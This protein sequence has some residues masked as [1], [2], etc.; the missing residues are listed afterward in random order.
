MCVPDTGSTQ[1]IISERLAQHANLA[2]ENV[3][4]K[5][6]N[7]SGENMNVVGETKVTFSN[8][9]YSIG[10]VAIVARDVNHNVL[11]SWH[12]LQRLGVIPAS[13]PACATT[14]RMKCLRELILGEFKDV[15]R[16]VL[17]SNPMNVGDMKIHL[18]EKSVPS[19]CQVAG[20]VT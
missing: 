1:T 2:V 14:S 7:A 16:D 4:I 11:V 3:N 17:S 12:D 13:F 6:V 19:S 15:H 10:T 18:T 5:L 9:R 20:I 8:D